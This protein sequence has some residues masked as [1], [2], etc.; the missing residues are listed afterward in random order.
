MG[1]FY[2]SSQILNRANHSAVAAAAY[3]SGE[4]LHSE[5]DGLIKDYGK[6][7][8]APE[9]YILKPKNA[10]EWV[11]DRERLWNEVEKIEKQK[12]AQMVREIRLALPNELSNEEQKE[13]LI[14]FC[15]ENFSDQGMVADI[16]IHRDKPKNPHAHIML[17]M[18]PFNPDGTWGNKRKKIDQEV[19]GVMKKVSVHL[20]DWNTKETLVQWRKD[21]ADK[22]NE[23]LKEKGIEDYVSHESYA[24]Q[25]LDRQPNIRLERTA[26]QIEEQAK[27]EAE[28]KNIPYVPVTYYG[29][30]N[31][32]ITKLN[33]EIN[34][35]KELK[36]QKVISLSDYKDEK[37][38]N[39]QF[40][41]IRS[42]RVL[43]DSEK[44]SLTMV[45]KRSKTYV[46][47]GV[48]KRVVNEIEEGNWKKKI[49]NEKTRIISEKNLLNKAYKAYQSDPKQVVKYG[50]IPS[51][52]M[53]Q[54]KGKIG[55]LSGQQKQLQDDTDKFE[56]LLSKAKIALEIQSEFTQKEFSVIYQTDKKFDTSEMYHAVQYF[57]DNGKILSEH[58]I[59][60]YCHSKLNEE[61]KKLPSL[62]EQTRNISKSIFILDRA[63]QKQSKERI[64][65]LKEQNFDAAYESSRK[66]EQ[67]NLQKNR[68]ENDL[69]GNVELLRLDLQK[70]YTESLDSIHDAEVLLQLH[71][72]HG[73][74]LSH[75]NV[76][77]DLR[78][79]Y[80]KFKRLDENYTQQSDGR[81]YTPEQRV[82]QDYS[83]NVANGLFQAL[84]QLQRA[85]D[86]KKHEKD[87]TVKKQ[88]RRYR[89][90]NLE[91]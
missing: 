25:G 48:A 51:K 41:Q 66:I 83:R 8:V 70:K 43:N 1:Y 65:A 74:G 46:D 32:E 91:H 27:R 28:L 50:F 80:N 61:N 31:A 18:R 79:I 22:I 57:K 58:E 55:E 88:K 62:A 54:M 69:K 86:D 87:S 81:L 38:F 40:A 11:A 77:D 72:R 49:D 68:H 60:N 17:T 47:Y 13:L 56:S 67:Y 33:A 7:A 52:F 26:Y 35:L 90:Q 75:G 73:K 29:K 16:S 71:D 23:K 12:N 19:N 42:S 6:R 30:M 44:S 4:K 34:T 24:K 36:N 20:T 14:S 78:E 89:G 9:C 39:E 5:R 2:F 15:K 63:I 82:E 3:R 85:N 37:G 59:Q 21:Y 10:P 45:A 64:A 76:E 84:E 53:D